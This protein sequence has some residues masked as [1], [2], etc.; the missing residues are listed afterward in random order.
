MVQNVNVKIAH[1][2]TSPRPAEA[3]WVYEEWSPQQQ[4]ETEGGVLTAITS[5]GPTSPEGGTH[6][7][8]IPPGEARTRLLIRCLLIALRGINVKIRKVST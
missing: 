4:S 5:H 2:G 7:F 3:V 1:R 8:I 6:T